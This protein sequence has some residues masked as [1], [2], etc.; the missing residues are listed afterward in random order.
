MSGK[1]V[2][3]AAGLV[4]VLARAPEPRM[5]DERLVGEWKGVSYVIQGTPHPL[6][7]LFIFTSKYFSA[8]VMFRASGGSSDDANANAGP[9][10]ADGSSVTFTQWMQLHVRSGDSS[11][12]VLLTKGN[13]ERAR[14]DVQGRR[15]VLTFPSQ[16][17]YVLE[18]LDD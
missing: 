6:E 18:R 13:P 14:Y 12:P 15:L 7:G 8:N 11:A 2:V 10:T 5:G 17:Q 9:Y 1:L 16:N 4:L 3:A